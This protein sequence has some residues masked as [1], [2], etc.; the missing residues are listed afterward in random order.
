MLKVWSQI[1]KNMEFVCIFRFFSGHNQKFF[2]NPNTLPETN[3]H[4]APLKI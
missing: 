2:Q 3:I 1:P 4:I